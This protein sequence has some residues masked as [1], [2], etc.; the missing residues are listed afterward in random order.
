MEFYLCETLNDLAIAGALID[1]TE[2]RQALYDGR[3][4]DDGWR[5]LAVLEHRAVLRELISS[6]EAELA[7]RR[8]RIAI[9]LEAVAATVPRS[10]ALGGAA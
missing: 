1:P 3:R 6:V 9:Y 7:E 8:T 4:M 10:R 5:M 2:R